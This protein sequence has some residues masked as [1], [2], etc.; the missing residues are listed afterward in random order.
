[1][2]LTVYDDDILLIGS[3]VASIVKS[4]EY[5]KTQFVT[6]V[7]GRPRYFLRIEI[8]HRKHGVILSQSNY[9]LDLLQET[10]LL[11]ASQ[12]IFLWILMLT[13][14]MRVDPF[15]RMCLSTGDP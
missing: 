11:G 2:M 14:R 12:C 3:N 15:L 6:K 7:M 9:A 10:E 8:Y 4:K 13:C 1:M 5:L